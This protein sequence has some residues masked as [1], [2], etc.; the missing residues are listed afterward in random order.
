MRC[1]RQRATGR[2]SRS[3]RKIMIRSRV[4]LP[5]SG[6]PAHCAALARGPAGA[7]APRASCGP[8]GAIAGTSTPC[9]AACPALAGSGE[10]RV[11]EEG[12]SRG[13]PDP[14]KKKKR[15]KVGEG[16]LVKDKLKG[17]YGKIAIMYVGKLHF[18]NSATLPTMPRQGVYMVQRV[19]A[20]QHAIRV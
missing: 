4:A 11:G 7:A 16:F 2:P 18:R 1:S 5:R 10:R 20:R 13:A 14:L 8:G 19:S 3:D 6:A 9:A 15:R 12:R 17:R